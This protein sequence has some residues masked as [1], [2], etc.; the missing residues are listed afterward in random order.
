MPYHFGEVLNRSLPSIKNLVIEQFDIMNVSG[1]NNKGAATKSS[2]VIMFL[3]GFQGVKNGQK[4]VKDI[5]H[6]I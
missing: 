3:L 6:Y 1:I 5:Q 2:D 4:W